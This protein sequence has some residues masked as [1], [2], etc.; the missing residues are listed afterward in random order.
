M[1]YEY[2]YLIFV[3]LFAALWMILYFWRR[4]IRSEMTFMSVLFGFAGPI[5]ETAHIQDWWQPLTIT[6][7]KIGLEDFLIGFF[8]GGVAASIYEEVFKKKLRP[9]K[10]S[11]KRAK[12]ENYH[13][14]LHL[15][16]FG[17]LFFGS[18]YLLG[19][20]S[21]YSCIIA[22]VFGISTIW[23]HRKDL[24]LDSLFSGALMLVIGSILYFVLEIFTPGFIRELWYLPDYWFST[25]FLGIPIAEYIGYFLAGAY[26]GPLYEFWKERRI[27]VFRGKRK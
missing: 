16:L 10:I 8:I 7:T 22:F 26:I 21:F 9:R 17:A 24:I 25:L 19:V 5:G 6:G 4:D 11:E 13:F 23:I 3:L 2:T 1:G 14:I 20:H 27:A 12:F 15:A 18:F